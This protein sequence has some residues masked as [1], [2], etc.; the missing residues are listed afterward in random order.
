ISIFGGIGGD[1]VFDLDGSV[2]PILDA[3]DRFGLGR[4]TFGTVRDVARAGNATIWT[5]IRLTARARRK[6]RR[7]GGRRDPKFLNADQMPCHQ[8]PH[9]WDAAEA[10]APQARINHVQAIRY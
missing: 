9:P 10:A 8:F 7:I 1:S 6:G 4:R 2:A 5:A 3:M